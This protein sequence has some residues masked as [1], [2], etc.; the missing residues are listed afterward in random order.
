MISEWTDLGEALEVAGLWTDEQRAIALDLL[1]IRIEMRATTQKVPAA[2]DAD[3]LKTLVQDQLNR[4]N[5]ELDRGLLA[6]DSATQAY[7]AAG[8]PLEEDQYSKNLRTYEAC[9]T[10]DYYRSRAELLAGREKQASGDAAPAAPSAGPAE[11]PSARAAWSPPASKAEPEIPERPIGS[12]AAARFV[13]EAT[14]QFQVDPALSGVANAKPMSFKV[15]F[16]VDE[17]ES[18]IDAE[19]DVESEPESVAEPVT[20]AEPAP[21]VRQ[22]GGRCQECL[23]GGDGE[24]SSRS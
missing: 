5:D 18:E 9:A 22:P 8:G 6:M 13:E 1:G 19:T 24:R 2:T 20:V 12:R 4:L 14:E 16:A 23:E 15:P 11:R 3:A 10:R 21:V 7:A 17:D